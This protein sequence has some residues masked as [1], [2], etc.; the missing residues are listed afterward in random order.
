MKKVTILLLFS[1]FMFV[2]LAD[3]ITLER[4]VGK[5]YQKVM[6][7]DVIVV[8]ETPNCVRYLIFNKD[9]KSPEPRLA[10]KT[11]GG[12][13]QCATIK[14]SSDEERRKIIESWKKQGSNAKI[15]LYDGREE[16]VNCIAIKYPL[17]S[18]LKDKPELQW[19]KPALLLRDGTELKFVN[20]RSIE[21]D[22]KTAV[23]SVVFLDGKSQNYQFVIRRRIQNGD[24]PG[25]I[26]GVTDKF[27]YFRVSLDQVKKIEFVK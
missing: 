6:L 2:T 20:L 3:E 27:T 19:H 26:T 11:E 18:S 12:D 24:L 22:P 5:K 10:N 9:F 23:S 25:V 15:T 13:E 1:A 17:A 4:K 7:K 16:M 14:K 21:F 8:E